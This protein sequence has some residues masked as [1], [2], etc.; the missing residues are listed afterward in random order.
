[1]RSREQSDIDQVR[2]E[3]RP[4][5]GNGTR[6]EETGQENSDG[7]SMAQDNECLQTPLQTD[8]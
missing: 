1:M 5:Q 3:K 8:V 6:E 4:K 7:Q 2:Q